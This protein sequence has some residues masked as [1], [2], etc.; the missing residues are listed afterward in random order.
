M[1][2]FSTLNLPAPDWGLNDSAEADV[3]EIKMGDGYVVRRPKGINY[4][5]EAWSPKW[6]LLEKDQAEAAYQWL[7]Q[8]LKV[9]PF[10]WIHPVSGLTYKVVC[11]SVSLNYTGF[12]DYGLSASFEQDFNP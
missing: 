7:K 10:L 3:D 12:G 8:R 2:D 6:Q 5:K 4:L 11:T 1:D 9:T